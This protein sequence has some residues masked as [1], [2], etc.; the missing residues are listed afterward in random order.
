MLLKTTA[1]K[2]VGIEIRSNF[3]FGRAEKGEELMDLKANEKSIDFPALI[4]HL[5]YLHS[6]SAY[7]DEKVFDQKGQLFPALKGLL[8]GPDNR[9]GN[10]NLRRLRNDQRFLL[11]NTTPNHHN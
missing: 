3:A 10:G 9:F 5:P 7:R 8:D 6:Y 1:I 2:L 11:G 4:G